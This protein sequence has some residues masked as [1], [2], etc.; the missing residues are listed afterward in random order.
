[1]T[2]IHREKEILKKAITDKDIPSKE[3]NLT[4]DFKNIVVKNQIQ[5]IPGFW[6]FRPLE[7]TKDG[8]WPKLRFGGEKKKK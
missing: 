4:T 7:T 6:T 5:A 1:M 2:K 3:D 8:E